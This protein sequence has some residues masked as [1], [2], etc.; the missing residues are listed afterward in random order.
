VAG[1]VQQDVFWLEVAVDVAQQVQV[2]QRHQ[3]L[4]CIEPA[5]GGEGSRCERGVSDVL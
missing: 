2:L 1:V 5:G 3:H 4:C